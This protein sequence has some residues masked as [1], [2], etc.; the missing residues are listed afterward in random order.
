MARTVDPERHAARRTAILESAAV[1]FATHGYEG[2][3]TAAIC[4]AAG[5]GSG[6]LFHYFGDKRTIFVALF[7]EDFA[8]V[9]EV[10]AQHHDQP[11]LDAYWAIVDFLTR[12]VAHSIAPGLLAAAMQLALKD[13]P[14]AAAMG[15]HDDHA[16]MAL[17]RH[18]TRARKAGLIGPS[19][20]P[21]RAARWTMAMVDGLYFMCG[22]DGFDAKVELAELRTILTRYLAG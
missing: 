6:T 19:I 10:V 8:L 1:V 13:E 2:T 3:T 15:A 12:D 17:A 11:P 7:E 21:A 20:K 16:R 5:I 14:F 22:D 18:L 9:H 4:Q